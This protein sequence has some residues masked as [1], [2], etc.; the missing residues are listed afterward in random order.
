M[1]SGKPRGIQAG[2]KLLN[3][4]RLNLWADKHYNTMNIPSRWKKPF[5]TATHAKGIV[6]EKLEVEAK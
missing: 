2:R 4:R 6:L 5:G 3:K 1:G